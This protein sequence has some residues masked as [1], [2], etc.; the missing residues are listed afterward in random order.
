MKLFKVRSVVFSDENK[1]IDIYTILNLEIYHT[2]G[3]Y[4]IRIHKK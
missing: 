2:R 3:T 1:V 4:R